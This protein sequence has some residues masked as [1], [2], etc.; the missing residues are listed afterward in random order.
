MCVGERIKVNKLLSV[1]RITSTSILLG[2]FTPGVGVC[3]C[4]G[5]LLTWDTIS[6]RLGNNRQEK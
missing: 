1:D 4:A 6:F 2:R 3:V 5:V